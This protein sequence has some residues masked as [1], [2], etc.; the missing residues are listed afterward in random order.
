M[1]DSRIFEPL[2]HFNVRFIP[3][4]TELVEIINELK[5]MG[6]R[7]VLTQGSYDLLHIGHFKY[8]EEGRA[9]GDILV[10]GV[11]SDAKVKKRKGKNRPIISEDE[12]LQALTYLHAVDIVTLKNEEDERLGLL[13]RIR[14]HVLVVSESTGDRKFTEDTLKELRQFCGE[15][16]VLPPQNLTGTTAIVRRMVLAGAEE[17][18]AKLAAKL[19]GFVD[20][21]QKE[22]FGENEVKK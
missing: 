17:F 1:V 20:N 10:V 4:Q 6:K 12:R 15:V 9:Q 8:L 11:D 22:V 3:D 19:P 5:D 2:S 16:I 14:P 7:I 18:K 13:K 21:L